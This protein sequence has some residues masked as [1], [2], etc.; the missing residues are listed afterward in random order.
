MTVYRAAWVCPIAHA[1]IRDGWFAVASQRIVRV[2][3]AGEPAPAS[4]VDLGTVAVLPGLVNAHTHVELSWLRGRV[5]PATNFTD[6][7]TH[8]FA[9]RGSR[10]ETAGD[11]N[12]MEAARQAAG[13]A[14]EFG[15]AA[16]GDIS[17]SLVSVEPI[18]AAGLS[19]IVLHE[20]LG[21]KSTTGQ[22]VEDTRPYRAAA[23]RLGGDAVRVSVSP[24]APYSVSPELF[25]AIRA[26]VNESDV[27]VTSV[28]VGE[29][30]GEIAFLQDGTGPWPGILA[31]V[32]ATRDDWTPPG[33]GPVE[34]LDSLGVLD[35]RTLVVHGVQLSDDS[36]RRLATI[37]ATLV[38][39][40]R[41]NQWVGVGVPPIERFYAS[42]VKLA[43]GT[44][45]LASVDDLNVFAEL[46]TM[47]WLAPTVP[48]ARLLES[49]TQV[50]AEALGLGKE[51]G[52]IQVGKQAAL[53]AVEL[54]R[55][56]IDVEEYLVSGVEARHVQWVPA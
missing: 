49:A 30:V 46:K 9:T 18:R 56:A 17:N 20:L 45:S 33:L 14:R 28:H 22:L 34:Y 53:I 48:A 3:E 10:R 27:P 1:P 13:E 31:W 47:R 7:I 5:P 16:V 32:G 21:F 42:G 36:L 11:L 24:H 55:A 38:T 43:V 40:P 41:S 35:A 15:T 50:G 52:T 12:V 39:C 23:A 19:G 37:G 29:S 44:D 8:L 51:L 6:W 26:E 4:A 2:G 54:P 25:R